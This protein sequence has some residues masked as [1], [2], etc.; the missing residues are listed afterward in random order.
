MNFMLP[1][2]RRRSATIRPLECGSGGEIL[3]YRR[4]ALIRRTNERCTRGTASV[5]VRAEFRFAGQPA[6]P[7][8]D[9][10]LAGRKLNSRPLVGAPFDPVPAPAR[11]R[12]ALWTTRLADPQRQPGISDTAGRAPLG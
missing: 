9:R 1:T 12:G 4:P 10:I 6:G 3:K 5:G 7:T 8:V 11:S 2:L